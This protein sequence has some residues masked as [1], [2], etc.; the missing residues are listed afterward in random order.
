MKTPTLWDANTEPYRNGIDEP[1]PRFR[2]CGTTQKRMHSLGRKWEMLKESKCPNKNMKWQ[3]KVL[4]L[5][6]SLRLIL[7]FGKNSRS[8]KFGRRP[9][10]KLTLKRYLNSFPTW[11]S[12]TSQPE[13]CDLFYLWLFLHCGCWLSSKPKM[14]TLVHFSLWRSLCILS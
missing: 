3:S 14:C 9:I 7:M 6:T 12:M 10:I 8:V 13:V 1:L 11:R 5:I 2:N 4:F